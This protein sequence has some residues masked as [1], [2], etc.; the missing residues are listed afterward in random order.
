MLLPW[1]KQWMT[2]SKKIGATSKRDFG[3]VMKALQQEY[4]GQID[5]AIAKDVISK[6]LS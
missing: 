6:K 1:K 4:P 2:L 5:G 3:K